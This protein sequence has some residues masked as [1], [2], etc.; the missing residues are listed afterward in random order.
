MSP[1]LLLEVRG[2]SKRFGS[3]QALENVNF[4][5][6]KKEI[7]GLVGDNGAGKSTLMKIIAGNYLPD[8]GEIRFE[9]KK[10]I[11]RTPQ[12]AKKLGIETVYQD[13]ALCENLD[14]TANYF[15][16]RELITRFNALQKSKMRKKAE[17]ILKN[18][19]IEISSVRK[20][21]QFLSGGQRQAI[22]VG[23]AASWG[24]K[25]LL[26]DEPTSALGIRES[27]KVLNLIKKLREERELGVVV[28]SHNLQH[29]LPIADRVVIL[30]HGQQV[31]SYRPTDT[32]YDEFVKLISGEEAIHLKE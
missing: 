22:A 23:R 10:A 11:L 27:H 7:V 17:E 14:V 24:A 6:G 4:N 19:S 3:V 31:G 21:V 18:L 15:L 28:I 30:R 26:L 8:E 29:V 20:I 32:T 9:G 1:D 2:I 5:V 25:L 13:L 12:V 16:G